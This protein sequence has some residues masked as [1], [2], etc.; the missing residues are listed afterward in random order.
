MTPPTLIENP[1]VCALQMNRLWEAAW[2]AHRLDELPATGTPEGRLNELRAEIDA[3]AFVTDDEYAA[4][5]DAIVD[6]VA[7]DLG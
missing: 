7:A 2:L 3:D 4:I 6:D 5:V 1:S